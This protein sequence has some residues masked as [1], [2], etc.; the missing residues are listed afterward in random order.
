MDIAETLD[1]QVRRADPDRWLASRLIDD[2]VARADVIALYAFE[3]ELKRVAQVTREPMMAE[4]RLTWWREGVD[5]I[6][7]GRKPRGHPVLAALSETITQRRLSQ[8]PFDAM[9]EARFADI[10]AEPFVDEAT[11]LAYADGAAGAALSL[12]LGVLGQADASAFRPAALAVTLASLGEVALERLPAD[13]SAATRVE[14]GLAALDA[15]RPAVA[16]LSVTA[17]PA[18][19]HLALVRARLRGRRP[20]GLEARARLMLASLRGRI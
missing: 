5:E 7:A 14:R 12:A 15:V 10:D 3:M 4:I 16:A 8:D 20:G 2:P 18:V 9:I 13:W 19:A 1:D 17:F 6:F 11:L